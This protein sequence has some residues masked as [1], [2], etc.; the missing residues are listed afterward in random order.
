MAVL[1]ASTVTAKPDRYE[2]FVGDCRKT[3]TIMEKNGAQ[4][5]RLLAGLVSG[6][7]TG[8]FV[9]TYEAADFGAAGAMLDKFLADPEGLG[10]I[11]STNTTTGPT[12]SFQSSMWVDVPL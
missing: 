4:N 1:A 10:L 12:A 7:A 2:D 3:K 5:V 9:F 8:S 11:T 6:E